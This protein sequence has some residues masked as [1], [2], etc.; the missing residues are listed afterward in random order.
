MSTG[1]P[2]LDDLI[3][4]CRALEDAMSPNE[5]EEYKRSQAIEWAYGNLIC[6]GRRPGIT[7]EMIAE[8]YDKKHQ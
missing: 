8:A 4:Q 3:K 6:T 1:S 7:R 5:R 2:E